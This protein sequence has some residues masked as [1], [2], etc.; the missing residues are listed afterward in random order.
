MCC[1]IC[2]NY[3][4]GGTAFESWIAIAIEVTIPEATIGAI[5]KSSHES[6]VL[7]ANSQETAE[8]NRNANAVQSI[9]ARVEKDYRD[10]LSGFEVEAQKMSVQ[11]AE[12]VLAVK[13]RQLRRQEPDISKQFWQFK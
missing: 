2:V 12:S 11:F 1:S 10:Y 4:N 3:D 7:D 5:V 6:T 8:K 13:V 9:R